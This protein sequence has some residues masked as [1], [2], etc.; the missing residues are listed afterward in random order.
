MHT[1]VLWIHHQI[2][3]HPQPLTSGRR[4]GSSTLQQV[5]GPNGL[6]PALLCAGKGGGGKLE[7]LWS[8]KIKLKS[9]LLADNT[10]VAC[11]TASHHSTKQSPGQSLLQHRIPSLHQTKPGPLLKMLISTLKEKCEIEKRK[12]QELSLHLS[13][14]GA[15]SKRS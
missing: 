12:R 7:N 4:H 5:I 2:V 13:P 14:F 8:K 15:C 3:P 10:Q 9:T 1:A 6:A 11:S